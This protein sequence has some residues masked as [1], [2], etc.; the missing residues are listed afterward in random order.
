MKNRN[1]IPLHVLFSANIPAEVTNLR[2]KGIPAV[3]LTSETT[4][5]EKT[6]VPIFTYLVLQSRSASL[7]YK[8]P[9]IEATKK[10][11]IL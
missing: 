9:I 11:S 3:S 4:K 1:Y 10:S 2:S 5:G 8:R 7:D 6:E